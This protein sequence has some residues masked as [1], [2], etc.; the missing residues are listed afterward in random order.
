MKFANYAGEM[1][2]APK[3]LETVVAALN[4]ESIVWSFSKAT[5]VHQI[6]YCLEVNKFQ[7]AE[8]AADD[9]KNCLIHQATCNGHLD[10]EEGE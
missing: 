1:T 7:S 10:V 5:E 4:D 6:R 3:D 2:E 8:M 9:F